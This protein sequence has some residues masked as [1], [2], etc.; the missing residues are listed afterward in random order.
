LILDYVIDANILMGMLISGKSS[1]KTLLDYYNF[2]LPDFALVE[3]DK[4]KATI[5]K[6]SKLSNYQ[7][8]TFA[9]QIFSKI[10]FIPEFIL[11]EEAKQKAVTLTSNIDI[12]DTAYVA[13]ALQLDLVLLS[14]DKPL[15]KGLKKKGFRKVQLFDEFLNSI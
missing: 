15:V 14:R 7:L 12:K 2:I 10:T 13:L 4:Y 5:Y 11:T 3:I 8:R 1:Y 9:Y 6:K